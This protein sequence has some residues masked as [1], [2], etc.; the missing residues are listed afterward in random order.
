VN[1]ARGLKLVL[2][3]INEESLGAKDLCRS[4]QAIFKYWFDE[5][6]LEEHGEAVFKAVQKIHKSF[7]AGECD[8]DPYFNY[9]YTSL[10]ST[11][12]IHN[13]GQEKTKL[14]QEWLKRLTKRAP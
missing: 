3:S 11:I 9:D 1:D 10:L 7:A 13:F 4:H 2:Q 12:L 6:D 8:K 5:E 14:L